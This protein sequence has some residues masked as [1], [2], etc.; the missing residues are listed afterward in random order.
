VLKRVERFVHHRGASHLVDVRSIVY[1]LIVG[2]HRD[3]FES[4][5]LDLA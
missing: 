5:H 4:D 3:S 2:W 1:L